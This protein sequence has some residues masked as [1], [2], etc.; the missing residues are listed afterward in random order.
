MG[1][2]LSFK[3]MSFTSDCTIV[4][5]VGVLDQSHFK[6]VTLVFQDNVPNHLQGLTE[7]IIDGYGDKFL[8]LKPI[9]FSTVGQGQVLDLKDL[10]AASSIKG[11][12]SLWQESKHNPDAMEALKL[13]LHNL[14]QQIFM[15]VKVDLGDSQIFEISCE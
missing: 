11:T 6:R 10:N 7:V 2:S 5:T 15:G 1:L 9:H 12:V 14:N 13:D 4:K 8:S 3:A